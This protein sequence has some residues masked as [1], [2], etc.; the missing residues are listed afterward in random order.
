M[1]IFG[2]ERANWHEKR[3]FERALVQTLQVAREKHRLARLNLKNILRA[4]VRARRVGCFAGLLLRA[5]KDEADA[6]AV[7]HVALRHWK[8]FVVHRAVRID[9]F[10]M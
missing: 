8:D 10:T 3:E 7:Y 5:Q 1:F 6:K 9:V 4:D 2:A